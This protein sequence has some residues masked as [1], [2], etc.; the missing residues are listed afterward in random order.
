MNFIDKV[1][2]TNKRKTGRI[3]ERDVTVE[4]FAKQFSSD[5]RV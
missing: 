3:V 2:K 4:R 1:G 5:N